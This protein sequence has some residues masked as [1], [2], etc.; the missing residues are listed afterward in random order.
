MTIVLATPEAGVKD[1]LNPRHGGQSKHPP[2]SLGITEDIKA[3]ITYRQWNTDIKEIF[4]LEL[5][6]NA[7][8][9]QLPALIRESW[10]AINFHE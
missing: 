9:H 8:G 2:T 4:A 5:E 3:N 6:E 1:F 7:G 10:L